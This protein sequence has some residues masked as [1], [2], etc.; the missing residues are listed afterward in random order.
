MI[1]NDIDIASLTK[2]HKIFLEIQKQFGNP[3]SWE[4]PQGFESLCKI[5]LE[6]QVSLASAAAHFAALE[7]YIVKFIPENILRLSPEELRA[8]FISKQKGIYLKAL[9]EAVLNK[10]IQ[11]DEYFK[12]QD[13]EIRQQLTAVKGIGAWTA[14]VY[15]M[16][17]LQRKDIFPVGDIAL[18]QATK[19]LFTVT[20]KDE[21]VTLSETWQQSK[22]LA[23]YFLWHWY[24]SVK[25]SCR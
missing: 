15:L 8:C 7:N 12:M 6:Q 17:C 3:P 23:A 21:I 2:Q 11:F 22:S 13:E 16:M 14:D 24:L 18:Q 4:R 19:K 5:I 9:A 20:T 10:T 1:V 25:Q